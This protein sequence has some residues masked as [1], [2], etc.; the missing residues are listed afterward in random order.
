MRR[1]DAWSGIAHD[2]ED[3]GLV[4]L[5]ADQQLSNPCLNCTHRFDRV[6]NEVQDD[7]LQLYAITMNMG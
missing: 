3:A 5:G 4:L 6:Q 2:D 7:L 1:I